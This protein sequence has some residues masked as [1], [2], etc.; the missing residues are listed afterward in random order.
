MARAALRSGR[1]PRS[2]R[3]VGVVKGVPLAAVQEAVAEGLSDLGENRVQE[4]EDRIEAVG[5]TLARWHCV[6]H[7]QQNKMARAVRLFDWIH[8]VDDGELARGLSRRAVLAERR[9]PVLV[10]VNVSGEATKHG[11]APDRLEELVEQ[12]VSLP[13]VALEG[14]MSIGPPVQHGE[15]AR[16]T[17]VRT[18]TLRD[19]VER[20]LGVRLPELSMGMSADYEVAIEEGST[21]VRIGR[22]LFGSRA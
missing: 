21:M 5:R 8:S 14:L 4:A 11:I 10:Q 20:A 16:G 18:R 19:G 17:F 1:D 6:G 12:V 13:G 15:D 22:A 9:L 7:L 2:I 3:I